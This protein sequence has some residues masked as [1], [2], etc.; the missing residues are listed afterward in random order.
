MK[1]TIEEFKNYLKLQD[2]L[3]DVFYNLTEENI[4]KANEDSK[5]TNLDC[6]IGNETKYGTY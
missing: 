6:S 4:L 1:F 5:E 2:S 3:G